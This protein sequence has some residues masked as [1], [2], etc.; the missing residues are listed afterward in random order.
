MGYGS[1]V[2][3]DLD[4]PNGVYYNDPHPWATLQRVLEPGSRYYVDVPADYQPLQFDA[5]LL[6]K[7]LPHYR[8]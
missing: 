4:T 6:A 5:E 7:Y 2:V 3:T 1:H 8:P